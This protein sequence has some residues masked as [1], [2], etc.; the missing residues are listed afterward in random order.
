M[1]GD[2]TY[3]VQLGLHKISSIFYVVSCGRDA[4]FYYILL[5]FWEIPF[6]ISVLSVRSLSILFSCGTLILLFLFANKFLNRE[7]G[8]YALLL[9]IGSTFEVHY[10][11]E[12]RA[13]ALATLLVVLS[14]Y[15]LLSLMQKPSFKTCFVLGIVN[16]LCIYTHYATFIIFIAEIIISLSALKLYGVRFLKQF[17][18]SGFIGLV[19]V[20]PWSGNIIGNVPE[21]GKTWQAAPTK[22]DVHILIDFFF[23]N[24]YNNFRIA[25]WFMAIALVIIGFVNKR[26]G[27]S[28][29]RLLTLF[30][31]GVIPVVVAYFISFKVPI[32]VMRYVMYVLPGIFLFLAYLFAALPV[33]VP[34]KVIISLWIFSTLPGASYLATYCNQDWPHAMPVIIKERQL[35][36]RSESRILIAQAYEEGTF[37]YQWNRKIFKHYEDDH[38]ALKKDNV[39]GVDDI[40]QLSYHLNPLPKEIILVR[41][42]EMTDVRH[43]LDSAYDLKKDTGFCGINISIYRNQK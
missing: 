4:P 10:A 24:D 20:L 39:Y 29:F 17:I 5:H 8:F 32:F 34:L 9:F 41:T 33:N 40:G 30:C 6:G 15:L 37:A 19:L 2:E 36:D 28:W 12:T 7:T 25:L 3:A 43:K 35:H 23:F 21:I 22:Y 42:S 38:E 14:F 13:Y 16:A 31:W 11:M 26:L 1:W 18:I 27:F